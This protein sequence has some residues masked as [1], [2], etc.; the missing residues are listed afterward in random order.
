MEPEHFPEINNFN[1]ITDSPRS[2]DLLPGFY[3]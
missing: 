3:S 1:L 2:K